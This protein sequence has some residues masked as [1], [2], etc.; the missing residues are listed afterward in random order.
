MYNNQKRPYKTGISELRNNTPQA[1]K[2]F[3]L[4]YILSWA[5][6]QNPAPSQG[7]SPTP[8]GLSIYY[9]LCKLPYNTFAVYASGR[10]FVTEGFHPD[11]SLK[12]IPEI[13]F[14]ETSMNFIPCQVRG[15]RES[16][17]VASIR[18]IVE[19]YYPNEIGYT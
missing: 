11:G 19:S 4:D 5:D 17:F 13:E 18:G 9:I 8:T 1:K 2:S 12:P 7:F 6:I 15:V 16:E 10:V 3:V 14:L